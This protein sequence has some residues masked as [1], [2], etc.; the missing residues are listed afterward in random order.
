VLTHL[1]E[2]FLVP[3][4]QPHFFGLG[5]SAPEK[6]KALKLLGCELASGDLKDPPQ[7]QKA[8]QGASTLVSTASSTL[9]RQPG[10]SI[11]TVDLHGQISLVDA[12]KTAGVRRFVYV[13]FSDDPTLRYPLT[14]AFCRAR[15]QGARVYVNP[16]ELFYGGLAF[17]CPR[18]Q[19][20]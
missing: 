5:T 16:G 13:S 11:E 18:V 17:A 20:S 7:I 4:L 12:A 2:P 9:S 10:D 14:E 3:F 6:V 15:N 19:L 1:A 8:C